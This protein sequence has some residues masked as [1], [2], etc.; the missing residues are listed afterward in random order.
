MS[1]EKSDVVLDM[2]K[3][4]GVEP[5]RENYI[6]WAYFRTPP[7]KLSAE[8]EALLPE[9]FQFRGKEAKDESNSEEDSQ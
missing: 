8:E 5:T 6:R 7:E 4:V 3:K 2:M 9:Q 1:L